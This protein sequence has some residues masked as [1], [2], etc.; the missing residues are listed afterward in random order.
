METGVIV[1]GVMISF[2]ALLYILVPRDNGMR[3]SYLTTVLL[4]Q[5]TLLTT[6]TNLVPI[7]RH[8]PTFQL[9]FFELIIAIFVCIVCAVIIM[10]LTR[11]QK[12][13]RFEITRK[14]IKE[15]AKDEELQQ[16]N[17]K[18]SL[19]SALNDLEPPDDVEEEELERVEV[20]FEEPRWWQKH[21]TR[22]NIKIFD[23]TLFSAL[24][25]TFIVVISVNFSEINKAKGKY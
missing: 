3:L 14:E 12:K 22:K 13:G 6:I 11:L 17:E 8:N 9:M 4:T 5:V 19:N 10:W 7:A 1:P 20:E 21:I 24:L 18:T 25:V 15:V 2:L 23:Y 16:K